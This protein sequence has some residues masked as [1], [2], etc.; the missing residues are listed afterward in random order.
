MVV[1]VV[2]VLCFSSKSFLFL[3]PT[4]PSFQTDEQKTKT[5]NKQRREDGLFS[6]RNK[7]RSFR[8]MRR[9]GENVERIVAVNRSNKV[10]VVLKVG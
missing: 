4:Y 7:A 9:I 6:D 1:V 8:V 10:F 2:V 5:T 3:T